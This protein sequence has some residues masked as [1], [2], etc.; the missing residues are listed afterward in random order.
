MPANAAQLDDALH[1]EQACFWL[2]L[3]PEDREPTE[4]EY[5]ALRDAGIAVINSQRAWRIGQL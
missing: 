4:E 5:A 2:D 3:I 1:A